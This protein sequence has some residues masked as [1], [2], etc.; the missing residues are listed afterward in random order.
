[1][2]PLR[3]LLRRAAGDLDG[4]GFEWALVGGLAVSARTQPRFTADADLAVAV[5]DDHA[6]EAM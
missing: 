2:T 4:L 3:E 6:A 1:M 5:S